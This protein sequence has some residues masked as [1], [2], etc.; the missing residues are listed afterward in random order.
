[1][2]DWPYVFLRTSKNIKKGYSGVC[3]L[4]GFVSSGLQSSHENCFLVIPS[5]PQIGKIASNLVD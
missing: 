1:M 5:H 3:V 2:D 4:S